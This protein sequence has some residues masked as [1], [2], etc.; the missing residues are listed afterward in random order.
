[1]AKSTIPPFKLAEAS[2]T[3]KRFLLR[4]RLERKLD[5]ELRG[6]QAV[7]RL[8]SSSRAFRRCVQPRL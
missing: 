4:W 6:A 7:S 8:R 2:D 3:R 1:M 5:L